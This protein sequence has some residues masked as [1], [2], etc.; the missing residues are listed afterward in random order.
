[1]VAKYRQLRSED[2]EPEL[3]AISSKALG[4]LG[5]TAVN[6]GKRKAVNYAFGKMFGVD[7]DRLGRKRKRVQKGSGMKGRKKRKT[8]RRRADIFS[9]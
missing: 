2:A 7:L 6:Y 5:N 3:K 8:A 4:R 1:M 9:Y